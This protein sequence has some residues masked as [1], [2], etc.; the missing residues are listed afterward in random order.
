MTD[1]DLEGISSFSEFF[2]QIDD[3]FLIKI[4]LYD[5]KSLHRMCAMLSLDY[6]MEEE[7]QKKKNN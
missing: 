4:Y 7:Y 1:I 3:E 6:Q 5:P 2:E